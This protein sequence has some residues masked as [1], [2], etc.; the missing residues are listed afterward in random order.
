MFDAKSNA[1]TEIKFGMGG[2]GYD[3]GIGNKEKPYPDST[4]AIY[5]EETPTN[6]W[7]T[8]CI[9]LT[10]ENP[11]NGYGN[12]NYV[13]GAFL[14]VVEKDEHPEG[15]DLYLDNIRYEYNVMGCDFYDD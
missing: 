13:V 10:D 11:N 6:S 8:Y 14:V 12:L 1:L 3:E 2:V 9:D 15:F 7:D 5:Q 4:K